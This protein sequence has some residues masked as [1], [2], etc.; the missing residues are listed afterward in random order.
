M[1]T[2]IENELKVL[3]KKGVH[4][5]KI[6]GSASQLLVYIPGPKGSDY[7]GAHTWWQLVIPESYPNLAPALFSVTK[8]GAALPHPNL[9]TDTAARNEQ[10][11]CIAQLRNWP[12]GGRTLNEITKLIEEFLKTPNWEDANPA[13]NITK[14]NLKA[15]VTA[16]TA[17]Q[18]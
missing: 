10:R 2:N 14:Q 5:E 1:A 16:W 17:T 9:H 12:P 8:N 4:V 3:M 11:L 15:L 13:G 18:A 6:N 7:D